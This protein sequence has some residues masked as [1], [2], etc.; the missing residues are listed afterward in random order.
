M[1]VKTE[2]PIFLTATYG[3]DREQPLRG[4]LTEEEIA[5]V[6]NSRAWNSDG[7]KYIIIYGYGRMIPCRGSNTYY[8]EC[9]EWPH[10]HFYD[11]DRGRGAF[12]VTYLRWKK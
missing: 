5:N 7:A 10:L 9:P 2:D 8:E 4:H 6:V 3:D 11:A 12:K 1:C